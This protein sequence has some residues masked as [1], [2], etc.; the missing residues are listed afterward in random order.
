MPLFGNM[1]HISVW[2]YVYEAMNMNGMETKNQVIPLSERK[3][4]TIFQ[5]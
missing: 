5:Y 4:T 1:H 3:K 2:I